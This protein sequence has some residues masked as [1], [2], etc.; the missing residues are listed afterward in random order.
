MR[1]WIVSTQGEIRLCLSGRLD[2]S[3]AMELTNS[4]RGQLTEEVLL[5]LSQA[6]GFEPFGVDVLLRELAGRRGAG[7][8]VRCAGVPPCV[9]ER[10]GEAGIAVEPSSRHPRWAPW[11]PARPEPPAALAVPTLSA[12]LGTEGRE[13]ETPRG[14]RTCKPVDAAAT[15]MRERGRA[16]EDADGDP[17]A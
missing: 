10:M 6:E 12:S 17:G 1:K 11:G 8:R 14:A 9:A 4:L 7:P 13:A 16:E 3:R 15:T 2:G 5:D